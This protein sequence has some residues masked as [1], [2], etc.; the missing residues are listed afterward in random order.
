MEGRGV[1]SCDEYRLVGLTSGTQASIQEE[2]SPCRIKGTS[3][4]IGHVMLTLLL[5]EA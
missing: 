3:A 2:F 4:P 1:M 5:Y